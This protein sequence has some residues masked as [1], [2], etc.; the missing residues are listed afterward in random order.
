PNLRSAIDRAKQK[1]TMTNMK[2]IGNALEMYSVDN[3]T[4]PK[5]MTDANAAALSA[6]LS[7]LYM[8]TVPPGDGWGNAWHIDTNA[9]GTQYTITSYAR[10]GAPG[11]NTGGETTDFN[12]DIIY[13][14]SS[15]FQSP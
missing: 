1:A 8:R 9:S 7:P 13:T 5:G 10:D 6:Y 4:Y 11:S 14:N 2:S 3:N 15:F 12:C